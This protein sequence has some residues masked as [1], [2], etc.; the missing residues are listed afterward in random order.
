MHDLLTVE[1]RSAA[2][3]K[4]WDLYYLYDEAKARW[5][6]MPLPVEFTASRGAQQVMNEVVAEAQFRNPLC[7]KVL[8]LMAQF[9]AHPRKPNARK[10]S[11]R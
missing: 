4:G 9:A 1:E 3:S 7:L 8:Q 11:T 6:L 5:L 10:A 2:R